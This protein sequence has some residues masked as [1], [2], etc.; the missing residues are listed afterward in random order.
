MKGNKKYKSCEFFIYFCNA[1]H[2]KKDMNQ[3]FYKIAAAVPKISVANCDYNADS[4][5][6]LCD[7]LSKS[8]VQMAIFPRLTTTGVTCGDLFRSEM[9][10][11]AAQCALLR[12]VKASR[13]WDM[14]LIVGSIIAYEGRVYDCG[15]AISRGE[16]IAVVP[17]NINGNDSCFAK[18]DEVDA[19]IKIGDRRVRMLSNQMLPVEDVKVA[20]VI[21]DDEISQSLKYQ[22]KGQVVAHLGARKAS[23]GSRKG[24]IE[25]IKARSLEL[26]TTYIYVGSG[27]GESTTDHVYDG[28][29]IVAQNGELIAQNEQWQSESQSVVAEVGCATPHFMNVANRNSAKSKEPVVASPFLPDASLAEAYCNDAVN[30]QV[31]A[32][33]RR[34][35]VT[36]CK[37]LVIGISGGLD[38]TLA[39]LIAVKTFDRMGLDRKGIIGVTMPGFGTT[40]RTYNNALVMMRSL[41]IT[42]RE[43]SIVPA[44]KQH[45]ADINHDINVHD[46]TYENSQ[47][48]ERTQLLMDIANQVNGMVLGTGDMSEL[49][50]GWATYN[51]DHMSMYGINAGV[52]KTL[53]RRLVKWIADNERDEACRKALLDVIDT[54]ISPELVPA[55][56]N[57]NIKQKTED[58]VGPYE[59]HDFFLYYMLKFGY[60]PQRIYTL[61]MEVFAELYDGA[62]IK[63]W[64][65][66]FCRRFFNQQFKRSCMPDGPCV[67]GLSLSPRGGWSMPSDASSAMWLKECESL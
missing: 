19:I 63:H 56:E 58:L 47:A 66:T 65:T 52:P 50:L 16:I 1:K 67:C 20:I 43:I 53:V 38:S 12:V 9:L 64:L 26:F 17:G 49:A 42:M 22:A 14:S 10:V 3:E 41:G 44:V 24:F 35:E 45:F 6:E 29:A 7:K 57:G 36:W 15:V 25:D 60:R 5:I 40:D 23:M 11:D 32:L 61:A 2:N 4:I 59:L 28:C 30:I 48:R 13:S 8:E 62:T 33:M 46:I 54:P 21:G 27:Y 34:M 39:L 51:G 37:N 31:L 55:D 18:G